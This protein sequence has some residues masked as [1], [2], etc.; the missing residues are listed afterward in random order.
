MISKRIDNN[1]GPKDQL[2]AKW[3]LLSGDERRAYFEHADMLVKK[4]YLD[5]P[6]NRDIL[7]IALSIFASK[8]DM[9]NK[10]TNSNHGH[11]EDKKEE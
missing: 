10:G 7:D 8:S 11:I 6:E 1:P 4:G 9:I 5:N 3:N 2:W